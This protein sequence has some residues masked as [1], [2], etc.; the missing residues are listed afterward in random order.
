MNPSEVIECRGERFIKTSWNGISVLK[1]EAT[2]YYNMSSAC[3]EYTKRINDWRRNKK[4][5]ELL[6]IASEVL[7]LPIETS[8]AGFPA[9]ALT[10]KFELSGNELARYADLQGHYI[11]PDL[12]HS[13][14]EWISPEYGF[15]VSRLMN[16]LN[17]RNQ[18]INQTLEQTIENLNQ[19]INDLKAH[20]QQDINRLDSMQSELIS[21]AETIDEQETVIEMQ[22]ETIREYN[23]PFNQEISKPMI[24]A[25]SANNNEFQLR[26]DANPNKPQGI[27]SV[28]MINAD[29]VRNE[30]LK[31][32]EMEGLV[33]HRNRKRLISKT[34]IDYVFNLI[35]EVRTNS[36]VSQ[37]TIDERNEFI[38]KQLS[39]YRSM[40]QTSLV[41]GYIYEYETIRAR[42]E[43]TPWKLVPK[44][45]LN[46]KGEN[47]KDKGIDAVE[48]TN[49]GEFLSII[50]IKHHHGDYLR[51]D[52]LQTFFNKCSQERYKD[53][54]KRLFVHNC[55]ISDKLRNLIH[56]YNI[57]IEI[58]N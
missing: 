43:L 37:N 26:Y 7:H 33:I 39:R 9:S 32:L 25:L 11:H 47:R 58:L 31:I 3:H 17:E 13:F 54:R 44:A 57:E 41:E 21:R 23:Q 35:E 52:E 14:A 42:P 40:R 28:S 27:R 56:S 16:L 20:H 55:K 10:F 34:N 49:E 6:E 48:L 53:V 1:H 45:I 12:F 50:Q 38:D 30:S 24:Y 36:R 15:K 51:K 2:G 22:N 5:N 29:Y 18:L 46:A 19:E 8:D 4:T